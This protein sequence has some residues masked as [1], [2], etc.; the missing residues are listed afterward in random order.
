M[1]VYETD[2]GVWLRWQGRT[3]ADPVEN[4]MYAEV[5]QHNTFISRRHDGSRDR[6]RRNICC[7]QYHKQNQARM[8]S[9]A[10]ALLYILCY[11]AAD[12]IQRLWA[13]RP[14]SLPHFCNL[15]GIEV[16]GLVTSHGWSTP[17]S[18]NR[19]LFR[20]WRGTK[21]C[22]RRTWEPEICRQTSSR[23]SRQTGHPGGPH[24]RSR[25]PTLSV[26]VYCHFKTSV[27]NARPAVSYCQTCDTCSRVCASRIGF[28]SQQRT[29]LW[30]RDPSCRQLSPT[31]IHI[32]PC[33]GGNE[34]QDI[35]NK[36]GLYC[37]CNH[38]M[39]IKRCPL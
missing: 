4:W 29:H 2:T 28:I 19:F 26:A 10:I 13:G 16:D 5:C 9:G 18:E 1:G 3:M 33:C 30:S 25:Y 7:I 36:I 32:D 20:S 39:R 38:D 23:T 11:D 22:W 21:I 37:T 27:F 8:R 35:I 17:V 31:Y 14:S 15:T 24:L 6:R 12:R 34:N